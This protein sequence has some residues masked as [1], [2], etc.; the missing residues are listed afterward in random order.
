MNWMYANP[1]LNQAKHNVEHILKKIN[2]K[3]LSIVPIDILIVPGKENS[4]LEDH[5]NPL[6]LLWLS[7]VH[8]MLG[9][10]QQRNRCLYSDLWQKL[11]I[12]VDYIK[13]NLNRHIPKLHRTQLTKHNLM[14][15]FTACLVNLISSRFMR[16]A[17]TW[18]C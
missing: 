12:N 15:H 13:F 5:T 17:Y 14:Y 2:R 8:A 16:I 9:T 11:D 4:L 18:Y 1:D 3:I 10:V 7:P 6:L